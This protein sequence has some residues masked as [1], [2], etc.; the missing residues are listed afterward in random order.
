[1]EPFSADTEHLHLGVTHHQR[2][3][4]HTGPWVRAHSFHLGLHPLH[5]HLLEGG[6]EGLVP[7]RRCVCVCSKTE[8]RQ[9]ERCTNHRLVS[10]EKVTQTLTCCNLFPDPPIPAVTFWLWPNFPKS[11]SRT[12]DPGTSGP[13]SVSVPT[14]WKLSYAGQ[15]GLSIANNC[16]SLVLTYPGSQQYS[17]AALPGF[18]VLP[19]SLL[20]AIPCLWGEL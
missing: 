6:C 7:P 16:E 3:L 12:M 8:R 10:E 9:K 5:P 15:Q 2:F 4:L 13:S 1:M 14:P 18:Q 19:L 20:T 17:L 11:A